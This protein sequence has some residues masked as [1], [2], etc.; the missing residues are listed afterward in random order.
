MKRKNKEQE[1]NIK[2]SSLSTT[3]TSWYREII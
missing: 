3:L 1:N 2:L